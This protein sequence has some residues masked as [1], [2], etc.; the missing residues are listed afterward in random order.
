M[1][2]NKNTRKITNSS[3]QLETRKEPRDT[4][5]HSEFSLNKQIEITG[6]KCRVNL[7]N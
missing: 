6:S 2:L 7:L 3:Q 4:K 5:T 1:R